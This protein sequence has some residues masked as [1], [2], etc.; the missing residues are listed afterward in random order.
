MVDVTERKITEERL[1]LMDFALDHVREVACLSDADGRI[2]HVNQE[3]CRV[4]G[5]DRAALLGMRATDVV[6]AYGGEDWAAR[7]AELERAG[8]LAFET[9]LV[10]RDG[11]KVPVELSLSR[12]EH[13]GSA[14]LLALARD[15]GERKRLERQ[16]RE[17]N[18][19][20]ERR[21]AM[22][23]AQY[24]IA[25]RELEAFAYSV[26]H[27]L[28]APLRHVGA[29]VELLRR[30]IAP[31]ANDQA[32]HYADAIVEEARRMDELVEG[33][34]AFSR[35]GQ[36]AMTKAPVAL[37][38]LLREVVADFAPEAAGRDVRW[39]VGELPVVHGDGTMLR[40]VLSNLVGNAL[41][42]TRPRAPAEIEVGA[43]VRD[44]ETI[45]F[46]R[47][48]GVGFDPAHA[49]KLFGIFERLHHAD[50]FEGHGIGLAH[51]RRIV[52]RHGGRTWAESERGKGATFYFS[53]PQAGG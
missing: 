32:R 40:A 7:S 38:A 20:L 6:A 51:V 33:L 8:S 13:E 12:F 19:T 49:G 26:S 31:V 2:L 53:L 39:R 4:L 52:S 21:V 37:G 34:L 42:F 18:Q 25:N 24:E 1:V 41:K 23:T 50:E 5:Y 36:A 14:Y 43:E 47:D 3:A 45:V 35:M 44:G 11:A 30:V 28:R 46:V 9:E 17:L 22:R 27:D 15:I 48:N 16:M 29:Y 10:R